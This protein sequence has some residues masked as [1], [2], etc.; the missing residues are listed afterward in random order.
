MVGFFRRSRE[1]VDYGVR[2]VEFWGKSFER[3]CVTL[4]VYRDGGIM[5]IFLDNE[6][7]GSWFIF[8]FCTYVYM[9]FRCVYIYMNLGFVY[10]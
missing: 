8:S 4:V 6:E 1:R 10:I 7:E 2:L 9:S 5:A 3:F